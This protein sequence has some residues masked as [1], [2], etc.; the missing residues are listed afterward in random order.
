MIGWVLALLVVVLWQT[1]MVRVHLYE[2]E[3][4]SLNTNMR[5][6]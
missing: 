2:L 6:E 4:L 1:I 3:R 5:M